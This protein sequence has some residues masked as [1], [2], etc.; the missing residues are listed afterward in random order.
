MTGRALHITGAGLLVLAA[1]GLAWMGQPDPAKKWQFLSAQLQPR[2]DT[3]EVMIEPA[4]L[5]GLMHNDYIDLRLIDVRHERDW[6]LFHLWG[7]QRIEPHELAAHREHLAALPEN[8][9]IVFTSNDEQT[10]IDAWQ[11]LMATAQQPNAY[12]LAGGINRWLNVFGK[13]NTHGHEAAPPGEREALRHPLTWA[14]GSRHPAA[15]PDPH[16]FEFHDIQEKV[17]L[18]KRV[19]KKGGCG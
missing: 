15:L 7:A 11:L 18:Q 5:L 16:D 2:L 9:V 14:L 8:G 1:L 19:V 4:E 6:N 17:K 12:I 13:D 3:R 10:A